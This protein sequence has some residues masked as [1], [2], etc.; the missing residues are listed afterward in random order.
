[1][2]RTE[3]RNTSLPHWLPQSPKRSAGLCTDSSRFSPAG[4]ERRSDGARSES[5]ALPQPASV[6]PS[7]QL[8]RSGD[9]RWLQG[10]EIERND[11]YL[12]IIRWTSN[13]PGGTPEHY[14]VVHYGTNP[15]EAYPDGEVF[16][17]AEPESHRNRVPGAHGRPCAAND[18]LLHRRFGGSQW[19]ERRRE[20]L[21]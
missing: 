20:E 15:K 11:A 17:L 12:V 1:M 18:L 5:L 2:A 10:P 19:Q 7:P 14:G 13:N 4:L 3:R 9:C 16:D 6:K 21:C 8:L